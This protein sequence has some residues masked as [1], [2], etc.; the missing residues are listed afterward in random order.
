MPLDTKS[1]ECSPDN[2]F[3]RPVKYAAPRATEPSAG[4]SRQS[5]ASGRAAA[6]LDVKSNDCSP[7]NPFSRPVSYAAPRPQEPAPPKPSDKPLD[8][9]STDCSP[10]NPFVRPVRF[11]NQQAAAGSYTLGTDQIPFKTL[12]ST[13]AAREDRPAAEGVHSPPHTQTQ[14]RH[15]GETGARHFPSSGDPGDA[16]VTW[17]RS[18]VPELTDVD[19]VHASL[20]SQ[21]FTLAALIEIWEQPPDEGKSRDTMLHE[22]LRLYC[23]EIKG[24]DAF[25]LV[26][27]LKTVAR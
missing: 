2:P 5:P 21:G 4:Q 23:P 20:K 19:H 18:G 26:K 6:P 13:K 10:D 12:I 17:L 3:A 25:R 15:Y 1:T 14:T 27:A 16:L 8:R 24:M 11:A 9:N 22:F 7:D